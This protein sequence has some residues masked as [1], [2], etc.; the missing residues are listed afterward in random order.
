M[1]M[2][3]ADTSFSPFDDKDMR[4]VSIKKLKNW[5]SLVLFDCFQLYNFYS[6]H[7]NG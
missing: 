5:T 1:I 4:R 6:L 2:L 3:A 7:E